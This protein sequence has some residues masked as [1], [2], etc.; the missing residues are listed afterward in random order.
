MPEHLMA[1]LL[2]HGP[3]NLSGIFFPH[4]CITEEMIQAIL[5]LQQTIEGVSDIPPRDNFFD[6]LGIQ[7]VGNSFQESSELIQHLQFLLHEMDMDEVEPA[8]WGCSTLE[9][10]YIKIRGLDT[11]EK[12]NR[13]I[14]LWIEW[15]KVENWA[16]YCARMTSLG[17]HTE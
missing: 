7:E 10:L 11:A 14:Q 2:T 8:N 17:D 5:S 12:I 3:Q 16:H 13:A 15:R 1:E 4:G 9:S 6:T